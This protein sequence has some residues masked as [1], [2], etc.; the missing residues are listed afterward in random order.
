MFHAGGPLLDAILLV[1]AVMIV[2]MSTAS[3]FAFAI[4]PLLEVHKSVTSLGTCYE[5]Q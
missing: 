3:K 4:D 1:E 5:F 2:M